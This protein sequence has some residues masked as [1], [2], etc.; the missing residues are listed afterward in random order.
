MSV[1]AALG[2]GVIVGLV[3]FFVLLKL[4]VIDSWIERME[5]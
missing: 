2:T 1:P 4:G 5:R 3:L